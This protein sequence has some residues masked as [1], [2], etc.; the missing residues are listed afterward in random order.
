M[1]R[2]EQDRHGEDR[3]AIPWDPVSNGEYFPPP[4]TPLIKEATKRAMRMADE[5]ARRLGMSRRRFLSTLPGAAVSL[6]ALSA[7]AQ[8]QR[9]ATGT[10]AGGDFS[11]PP[12]STVDRDTAAA[13]LTGEEFIMDVQCHLLEH[14][15]ATPLESDLLHNAFGRFLPQAR[16]GE[17]DPRTCFSIEQFMDEIFLK[18]D[19]NFVV[20]SAI[21]IPSA[22]N[23]FNIEVMEETIRVIKGLCQDDRVLA[24]GHAMPNLGEPEKALDEM[25]AMRDDHD[26][27]AWKVYTHLPAATGFS[28]DDINPAA[29]QVGKD[30][31][32]LVEE[33]GPNIVCVHKGFKGVGGGSDEFASPRDI[34]PAAKEHPDLRFVV[35]HSGFDTDDPAGPYEDA[36]RDVGVNRLIS[37]MLDSGL[38]PNSNVYAE[39]GSTW[40][41]LMRDP[42]K[43]AHTIGKLLKYV[44][45]DRVVWGTDSIW[46]GTP[47][48]QIQAFRAFEISE[49]FQETY[50]YP[51]LTPEIKSKILGYSS[52]ALYG[53]D[54]VTVPCD[55][56]REELENVRVSLPTPRPYG[57]TTDRDIRDLVAMHG[58]AVH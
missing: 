46:Y 34:G 17:D 51:A 26:I 21:P 3:L 7:C 45:E 47:Q 24:H 15:L 55:F 4:T 41:N 38:E 54:P 16:C 2:N 6:A 35:Y 49:E 57:P 52:A 13:V 42:D 56:S 40:F 33:I 18:S 5:S 39:L 44:G 11:L 12:D 30:F 9:E 22:I 8:E 31:L 32:N 36:S 28:F 23:P 20:L 10:T 14:D 29:P 19:T 27:A 37:S 1:A 50:G 53:I 25:R 48:P 58:G 43:A